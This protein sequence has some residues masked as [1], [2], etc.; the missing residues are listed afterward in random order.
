MGFNSISRPGIWR[1]RCSRASMVSESNRRAS[2]SV[3]LSQR[4]S[5]PTNFPVPDRNG[6]SVF[7]YHYYS[8]VGVCSSCRCCVMILCFAGLLCDCQPPPSELL[9]S[10][11]SLSNRSLVTYTS[12]R[13]FE[14]PLFQAAAWYANPRVQSSCEASQ[15]QPAKGRPALSGRSPCGLSGIL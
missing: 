1:V 15:C 10:S 9:S 4:E 2:L 11:E 14:A 5:G 6:A 12:S 3:T 8:M 7:D 13:C